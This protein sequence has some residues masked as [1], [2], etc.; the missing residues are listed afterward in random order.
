MTQEELKELCKRLEENDPSLFEINL[1]YGNIGA[2]GAR[3]LR[4]AL[5]KNR[6]VSSVHV[7]HANLGF[8]GTKFLFEGLMG[9]G[10]KTVVSLVDDYTDSEYETLLTLANSPRLKTKNSRNG[11]ED[12]SAKRGNND[13]ER[14]IKS[15]NV[16]SSLSKESDGNFSPPTFAA[17]C[18]MPAHPVNVRVYTCKS[19]YIS[20][21]RGRPL[22]VRNWLSSLKI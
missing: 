21:I 11:R 17:Q 3:A 18:L 15:K 7:H 9:R 1:D 14:G 4:D 2:D 10:V 5:K 16:K 12:A 20:L 8:N 19:G 13:R 6:I 22:Y